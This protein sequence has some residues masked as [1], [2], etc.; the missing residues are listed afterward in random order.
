VIDDVSLGRRVEAG[1][2]RICIGLSLLFHQPWYIVLLD[3]LR[4]VCWWWIVFRSAIL[5]KRVGLTWRGRAYHLN[6]L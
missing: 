4:E 3:P 2:Y 6:R 5:Y 1:G